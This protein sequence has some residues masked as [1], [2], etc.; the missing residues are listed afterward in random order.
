MNMQL[1]STDKIQRVLGIYKKLVSGEIVSKVEEANNYGVNERSI[2]RDIDD[3]RSF[4]ESEVG[5]TG[6]INNVIYDRA[7]KGFRL[8]QQNPT[9]LTNGQMLAICKILLD[10]RALL[11]TDMI[12]IL[13]K[14]I[15][16]CVTKNNQKEILDLI[17]NERFHYIEPRH[18][19]SFLDTM[20]DIGQAIRKSQYIHIKY[21]KAG[22]KEIVER[23]LKPV[24]IMFSEYYFYVTAFISDEEIKKD[25]EVLNDSFPTI[26][27]ID[28]IREL[29]I[30]D[31]KFFIPYRNR[32]EEGEFRKR[33]QFMYGGKLRN[34]KFKYTG[35]DIDAILDRLPTAQILE[36]EKG[37]YIVKAIKYGREVNDWEIKLHLQ[38]L[39]SR[40]KNVLIYMQVCQSMITH[41][42]SLTQISQAV[43]WVD[44]SDI[45][46]LSLML[47]LSMEL[48]QEE[49]AEVEQEYRRTGKPKVLKEVFGEE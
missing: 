23:K 29:K 44:K 20:W 8:E 24:A 37:Y 12:E 14:L 35:D 38:N 18:K 33:I 19:V 17:K 47:D 40:Q 9:E 25:F 1:E 22:T 2:Q 34:V 46:G 5:R 16:N 6:I 21:E 11:K 48:T 28:R 32:F 49:R 42:F 45:Y 15:E 3:I 31:E 27:R 36:E 41:G 39:V 30:L 7:K 13:N 43:P 4:M 10:S 26:Y